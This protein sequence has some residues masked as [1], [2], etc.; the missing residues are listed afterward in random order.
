MLARLHGHLFLQTSKIIG[1]SFTLIWQM[2]N[3]SSLFLADI[4][5]LSNTYFIPNWYPQTL[6]KVLENKL[7]LWTQNSKVAICSHAHWVYFNISHCS[8]YLH[9]IHSQMTKWTQ[10]FQFEKFDMKASSLLLQGQYLGEPHFSC[11]R[12]F[13][14]QMYE[15]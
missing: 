13:L 6:R 5:S 2:T 12:Y 7:N 15:I 10:N 8:S 4:L 1:V 11:M 9:R 14:C 3:W